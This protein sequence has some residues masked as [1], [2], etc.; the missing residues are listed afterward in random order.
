MSLPSPLVLVVGFA[1]EE[2]RKSGEYLQRG[3]VFIEL[4]K[5]CTPQDIPDSVERV[6]MKN[7]DQPGWMTEIT[8]VRTLVQS[9]GKSFRSSYTTEQVERDLE[10]LPVR[11]FLTKPLESSETNAHLFGSNKNDRKGK[12]ST[13][14]PPLQTLDPDDAKQ[15]IAALNYLAKP[16]QRWVQQR[17]EYPYNIDSEAVRLQEGFLQEFSDTRDR[18]DAAVR[19]AITKVL[20]DAGLIP[21]IQYRQTAD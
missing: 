19:R 6:W 16:R 7:R 17:L 8:R 4:S 3:A 5:I 9:C 13:P 21:R 11:T 2:I 1:P 14:D 12:T 18:S 15:K 10:N 20:R